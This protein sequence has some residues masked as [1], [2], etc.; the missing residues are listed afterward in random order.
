MWKWLG[1]ALLLS[2]ALFVQACAPKA[3]EDCGFVQNSYGER[4]SWKDQGPVTMYIHESVPNEFIPAIVSAADT[5]ERNAGHK[6]FNI[7]TTKVGGDL[8]PHKDGRNIIYFMSTWEA[9]RS[10]EQARTNL[11]WVGDQISEGDIRVNAKDFDFYWNSNRSS[12][13]VNIEALILHELG[14][15]LGL[16][17]KDAGGSVMATYLPSGADRVALASTDVSDLKC[18]Y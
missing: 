5:W 17:H 6:L 9:N 4:V 13:K 15:V 3:Q 11:Y 12:L 16:K 8:A 18:E 1:A 7:V 14:H 2:T 10:T